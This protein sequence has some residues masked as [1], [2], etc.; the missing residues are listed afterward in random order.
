MDELSSRVAL[1]LRENLLASICLGIGLLLLIGGLITFSQYSSPDPSVV[2]EASSSEEPV[3]ESPDTLSG[4]QLVVDVSGAVR[5]PG[6]Y[7][8]KEKSR[9]EDALLAAGGVSEDADQE[10]IA[11][12]VNLASV[13]SDGAKVYIPFENEGGNPSGAGFL[14]GDVLGAESEKVNLNTASTSQLEDLPGIGEVTAGKIVS[15]RPYSDI[16]E[17]VKK[18]IV[19]QKVYDGIKE[20]VS[21]Y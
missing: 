18:K 14:G 7:R 12:S 16:Q 9:I 19:S 21:V 5:K 3:P 8:L 20:K 11:R 2:F 1:F 15:G 10:Y 13:L 4:R 6:V 17:L